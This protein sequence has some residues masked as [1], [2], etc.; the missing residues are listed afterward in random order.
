[1][2][3]YAVSLSVLLQVFVL[4]VVGAI[5]DRSSH[6]KQLLALFAYIGAG[7]DHRAGVPDR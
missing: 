1:M 4:P 3:A 2:F 7:G 6:K 5:A